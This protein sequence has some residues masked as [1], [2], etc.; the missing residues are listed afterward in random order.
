[1]PRGQCFHRL[2]VLASLD[3]DADLMLCNPA[4]LH[5]S[6]LWS[7]GDSPHSRAALLLLSFDYL[8][9]SICSP[10]VVRL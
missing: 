8:G 7:Q 1:V 3:D 6:A 10:I 5:E 2:R 9:L 4:D